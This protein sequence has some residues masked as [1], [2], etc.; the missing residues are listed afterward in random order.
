MLEG[1][2]EDGIFS[3]VS[4]ALL[5]T[6]EG[7]GCFSDHVGSASWLEQGYMARGCSAQGSPTMAQTLKRS[8]VLL[9]TFFF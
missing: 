9:V 3:E 6:E 1:I 7:K 4:S 2:W 8:F 5:E